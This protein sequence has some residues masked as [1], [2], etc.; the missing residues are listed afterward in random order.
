MADEAVAGS[1]Y[2][3]ENGLDIPKPVLHAQPLLQGVLFGRN[4]KGI[5]AM[6]Q[7]QKIPGAQVSGVSRC[8]TKLSVLHCG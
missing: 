5:A 2:K 1:A 6:L 3:E 4:I 8:H 7:G